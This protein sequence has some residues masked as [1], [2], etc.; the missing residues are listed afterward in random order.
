MPGFDGTGPMGMGPMTGRGMGFCAVA[1][2]GIASGLPYG[3]A[4]IAGRPLGLYY[5]GYSRIFPGAGYYNP[6]YT[7]PWFG[8]GRGRGR[9]RGW[10]W[11]GSGWFGRGRGFGRRG[12]FWW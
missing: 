10:R 6:Y 5:G 7:V 11:F 12:L 2:P 1:V 3:Y 8:W 9:G 4:G